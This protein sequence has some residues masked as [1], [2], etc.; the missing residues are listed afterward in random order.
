MLFA[1]FDRGFANAARGNVQHAEEGD[2]VFGMHGQA[3]VGESVLNFGAFVKTE[4][5]DKFV[6]NAAASKGFFERAG[7][8][9]GAIFDGAG[10]RGIVVEQFLQFFGDEFSFGLGVAPFEVSEVGAGG[11]LGAKS[12][13]EAVGIIVY[14]GTSGVEDALRGAVVA[15]EADDFGVGKIAREAEEDGN[16][17][18]APAIDRLVFITN[19]ANVVVRA[20]QQ[21]QQIVLNAIGVLIFVDVNILEAAL[22]FFTDRGGV[23]HEL[24]GTKQEVIEIEGFALR[25]DFVVLRV[26]VGG[27][28]GVGS[29]SILAQHLGSSRVILGE[30]D[31]AK[32]IARLEIVVFDV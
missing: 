27:V 13:S 22:P 23:T 29:A 11:L 12:F 5:T 32:N 24:R 28:A 25:E 8:K 30:A 4:T 2:V 17:G 3:N 20:D 18:A 10:L 26:D 7:L 19:D 9:I 14:D 1:R 21:A 15:F 6:A 31:L 16:I